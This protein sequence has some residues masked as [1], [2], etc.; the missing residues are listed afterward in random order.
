VLDPRLVPMP[1]S[2]ISRSI[3]RAAE[4]LPGLRRLPVMRLLILGEVVLLARTHIE[5]LTPK[6]RR[7]LVVLMRTARGRPSTLSSREHDELQSLIQK[8]EPRM[9]VGEAVER[10]SPVPLP[11]GVRTRLRGELD[12]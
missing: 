11:R 9:F 4:R 12:P 10:L 7:R 5:R 2:P 1:A 3:G 6:E 8:A